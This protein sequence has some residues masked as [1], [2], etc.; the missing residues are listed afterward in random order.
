M[1]LRS[2]VKQL[3]AKS[4]ES[5]HGKRSHMTE[6]AILEQYLQRL[7]ATRWTSEAEARF[8]I[9]RAAELLNWPVPLIGSP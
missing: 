5:K 9:R 4:I 3:A 8:I 7:I 2:S 6:L 1:S